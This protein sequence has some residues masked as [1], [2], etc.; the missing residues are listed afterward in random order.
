MGYTTGDIAVN[1]RP[2]RICSFGQI[3]KTL[4]EMTIAGFAQQGGDP[5]DVQLCTYD[6]NVTQLRRFAYFS[7]EF[8]DD[9]DMKLDYPNAVPGWYEYPASAFDDFDFE[10][11]CN[12]VA[13]PYGQG[14]VLVG[15][16]SGGVTFNSSGEVVE[17]EV[18]I[19]LAVNHRR[20]TGNV[21]P[22]KC[23]VSEIKQ[24]GGDPE[25]IQL[26]TYN[27]NVQTQHRYAYFGEEFW[28]DEDNQKDFPG[29][30]I[31]WYEYPESAFDDF[32]LDAPPVSF[33]FDPNEGFVMVGGASGG[34]T[35]KLPKAIPDP[36]VE[37]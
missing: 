30:S 28:A 37:D 5:E 4:S 1:N 32:E 21:L 26:Y 34:A 29:G 35:F 13:L 9:P 7:K 12:D 18:E 17:Q 15:G 33:T 10:K 2:M 31:G 20:M 25:D 19:E 11:P 27:N 3:G 6:D 36:V 8:F 16:A 23:N 24:V 14:C 22:R